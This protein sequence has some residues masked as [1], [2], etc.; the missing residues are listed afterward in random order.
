MPTEHEFKYVLSSELAE[1]YSEEQLMEMCDEHQSIQQGYLAFGK[2]TT[3]RIR[4]LQNQKKHQW[5]LTFKQ[6]VNDR[7][8]EI[9][10]K[11]DERDGTDLWELCVG[12]IKKERYIFF[13]RGN[14]WEVD[15]FKK[16]SHIYFI[17]AEVELSEGSPR[18]RSV[19]KFM[20]PFV[21]YEV[22]LTDDRFSNKRLGDVEYATRMYDQFKDENHENKKSK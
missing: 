7:V 18:P 3:T 12:K 6:K 16:G 2:G 8:I 5:F 9:E 11:L 21:L 10:K 22:P 19:P 15:L 17:L 13:D 20:K 14:N 4:H 1:Q